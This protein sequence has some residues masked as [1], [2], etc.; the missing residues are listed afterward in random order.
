MNNTTIIIYF[1]IL[2]LIITYLEWLFQLNFMAI[3]L[4]K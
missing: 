1:L 4:F 3:W 2:V